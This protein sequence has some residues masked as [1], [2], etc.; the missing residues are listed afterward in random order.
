MKKN[1]LK[2]EIIDYPEEYMDSV[3]EF[4]NGNIK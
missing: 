3:E 1:R 2:K 4:L